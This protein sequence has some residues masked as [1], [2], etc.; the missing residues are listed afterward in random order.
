[1]PQIFEGLRILDLSQ[2]ISGPWTSIF[3]ADQGAEVIKVESPPFGEAFRLFVLFDKTIFPLLSI[4]NR[5]K[6]SISL[7]LREKASKPIFTKLIKQSDVLVENFVKG[8]ME[9]WGL[10]YKELKKINPKLIYAK[11]SGYGNEGL[12]SYTKKT[13]FDIIIQAEAGILDALGIKEG[14]PKLPIAD[15]SAGHIAAIAISQALYY[16]EKTGKG[17]FIDISMHDIMFSIN[18]R[19][20]AKEFIPL[21]TKLDLGSKFLPIYNQYHTKDGLIAM[22]TLTEKQF[23]RLCREILNKPEMVNDSRF[24]NPIKRFYHVDELDHIIEDWTSQHFTDEALRKFE[25]VRIPCGKSYKMKEVQSHPQLRA[26]NMLFDQF[27]FSKWNVEKASIP[28]PL[29]KFSETKGSV[30]SVGPEFGQHNKEI[31]YDLLGY[32]QDELKKWKRKKII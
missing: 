30:K 28:G 2:F 13:A 23:K 26:R 18:M 27:D 10:G 32:S 16:R 8:T 3:F 31:Y 7:N 22:T 11:I 6:K 1:M 15:Y 5:G 19:A 14:P 12:E 20:H 21:A 4:L 9:K 24:E 25:E 29:I 17:Q